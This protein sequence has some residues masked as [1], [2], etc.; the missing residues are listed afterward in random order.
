MPLKK[1]GDFGEEIVVEAEP[2]VL[3]GGDEEGGFDAGFGQGEVV[4]LAVLDGDHAVELTMDDEGGRRGVAD[5]IDGA[6][7][8]GDGEL[9]ID[10]AAEEFIDETETVAFGVQPGEID[11]VCG[12]VEQAHGTD[13]LLSLPGSEHGRKLAA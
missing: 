2:V 12:R 13:A 3:A 1:D 4:A 8:G 11:H 6:G 10:P 5:V 7:L 9:F